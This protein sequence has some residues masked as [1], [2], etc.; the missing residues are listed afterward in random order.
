MAAFIRSEL[1]WGRL[2]AVHEVADVVA[3]LVSQRASW[4]VGTCVTVDGGQSRAF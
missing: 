1:P 3:F 2:G 4:V